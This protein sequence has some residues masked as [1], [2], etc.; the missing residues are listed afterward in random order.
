MD[1][2]ADRLGNSL[3][4]GAVGAENTDVPSQRRQPD[5]LPLR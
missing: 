5:S 1:P 4:T 3:S 2:E